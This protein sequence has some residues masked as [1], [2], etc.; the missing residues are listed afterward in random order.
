LIAASVSSGET[1]IRPNFLFN[2]GQLLRNQ[3]ICSPVRT[4]DI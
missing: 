3:P 4:P 1:I 2:Y